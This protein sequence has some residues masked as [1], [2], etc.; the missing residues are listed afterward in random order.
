MSGD[1]K[2]PTYDDLKSWSTAKKSHTK[3]A[4]KKFFHNIADVVVTNRNPV[5]PFEERSR[6]SGES[7]LS[8]SSNESPH[9]DSSQ[10]ALI[11]LVSTILES[12][13]LDVITEGWTLK[14]CVVSCRTF[15]ILTLLTQSS[16]QSSQ[17]FKFPLGD[18]RNTCAVKNDGGVYLVTNASHSTSDQTLFNVPIVSFEVG[19]AT[20]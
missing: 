8:T 12:N 17:N 5:L 1:I 18:S 11:D 20:R 6:L 16:S 9:Q 10:S 2:R 15:T 7:N 4:F 19:R 14:T 13:D 3:N